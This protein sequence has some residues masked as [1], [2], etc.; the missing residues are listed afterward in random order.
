MDCRRNYSEVK[1]PISC[2]LAGDL[3]ANEQVRERD[4]LD[5]IPCFRKTFVQ[6][7]VYSYC[8]GFIIDTI[9]QQNKHL[10]VLVVG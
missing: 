4:R 2:F 1:N 9:G 7:A 5:F 8:K 6:M 10:K 3:R